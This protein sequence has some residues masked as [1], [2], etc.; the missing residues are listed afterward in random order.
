ML[1]RYNS[2]T[3]GKSQ[4][5]D[6]RVDPPQAELVPLHEL[7]ISP[8]FESNLRSEEVS[9]HTLS[10]LSE[11]LVGGLFLLCSNFFLVRTCIS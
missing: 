4:I 8:S 7:L 3:L 2:F 1:A 11:E 9:N 10:E 5:G 6:V